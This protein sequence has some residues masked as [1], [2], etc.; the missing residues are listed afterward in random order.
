MLVIP[1]DIWLCPPLPSSQTPQ[2][3]V[4]LPLSVKPQLLRCDAAPLRGEHLLVSLSLLLKSF[5][6]HPVHLQLEARL[7]FVVV[8]QTQA[9]RYVLVASVVL[10]LY[11]SVSNHTV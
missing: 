11:A 10:D 6:Q 8:A 2:A 3:L 9:S 1:L 4:D 7:V 5:L